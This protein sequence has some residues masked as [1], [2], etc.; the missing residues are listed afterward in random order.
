MLVGKRL[1]WI[2]N[3]TLVGRQTGLGRVVDRNDKSW[4][5]ST[6]DGSTTHRAHV[7]DQQT[8]KT[9]AT[10]LQGGKQRHFGTD[11]TG[12]THAHS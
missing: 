12:A 10:G 6:Q 8:A 4:G 11:A 5:K 9:L 7:T 2:P 3:Q 1:A